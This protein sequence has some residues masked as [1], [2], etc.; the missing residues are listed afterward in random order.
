M[1]KERKVLSKGKY[2]FHIVLTMLA[3]GFFL[4]LIE[5]YIT[6]SIFVEYKKE[7]VKAII[8][9]EPNN[10]MLYL[11]LSQ[12]VKM[13]YLTLTVFLTYISL[14]NYTVDKKDYKFIK[15]FY[16]VAS[17]IGTLPLGAYNFSDISDKTI[18]MQSVIVIVIYHAVMIAIMYFL[19]KKMCNKYFIEEEV[20]TI[21]TL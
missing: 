6:D 4:G 3:W 10:T 16:L 21:E 7:L 5:T 8:Y 20:K 17:I 14:K 19:N 11:I 2:A 12:L 18:Q 1:K 13:I 9:N 15:I